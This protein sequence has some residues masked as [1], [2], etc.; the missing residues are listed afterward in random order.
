MQVRIEAP[1]GSFVKR[2]AD[3]RVDYVSPVP[4]PFNYGSVPGTVGGD[5]DP[6]DAIVLG[7][8]LPRGEVVEVE[9]HGL[10]RFWDG[11]RRDDKLVC[12]P[13]PPRAWEWGLVTAFFSV[14]ARAKQVLNTVRGVRGVTRLEEIA[15]GP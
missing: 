3:G 6:L 12:A 1:R 13:R 14:F 2:R 9:V 11:G 15:R 7:P 4:V 10:V 8:P 5:G